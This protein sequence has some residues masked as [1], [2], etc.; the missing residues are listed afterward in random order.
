MQIEVHDYI[1]RKYR[2]TTLTVNDGV[3]F[4]S[5]TD[6]KFL[7]IIVYYW[8]T[9]IEHIRLSTLDA[10]RQLNALKNPNTW[11]SNL[12]VLFITEQIQEH[13]LHTLFDDNESNVHDLLDSIG[14]QTCALRRLKYMQS[15]ESL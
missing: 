5:Q 8:L 3:C 2:T 9:F 1:I 13:S 10:T 15:T 7:G 11:I 4:Q 6:A 14:C 12:K